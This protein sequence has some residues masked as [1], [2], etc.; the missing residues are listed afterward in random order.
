MPPFEELRP[1][2]A[3]NGE[4]PPDGTGWAYEVKWDGVRALTLI[5]DGRPQLRSRNGNDITGR[6]PELDGLTAMVP[7][8]RVILDG[9]VVAFDE[10]G[11]PSF[12]LLQ[13]R[14]HVTAARHA[15]DREAS[16]P[17]AYLIFDL[18]HLDGH[19][20]YALP[21]AERRRLLGDL[22]EP[23]PC[24]QIP[25]HRTAEGAALLTAVKAQGLEGVMAKRLDAPYEPGRR[26]SLWR[27][28]KVR[29]QQELVVGGWWPG[30][31]NRSDT[32]GS[33]LVGYYDRPG[34]ELRFAGKV[35]SGFTAAGL[36][37]ADTL[38][39]AL[40]TDRSPFAGPVPSLIAR[41]ARWVR[42]ERVAEVA[43]GEWTADGVLRHPSFLGWRDDKDPGEIV[44][45]PD[46]TGLG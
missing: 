40:A 4:L 6:Y 18:L 17:V 44:R 9:E 42:P 19:D 33:L 23:G 12:G 37:E 28:V 21:Y 2:T 5:A 36:A 1:M 13:T 43:F 20:L 39:R 15:R 26:S 31:G 35:G 29:R 34:G 3:V 14:M 10:Q 8:H 22:L 30:E 46:P 38:L 7:G 16:V 32:V 45:E 27:K 25:A 24:W 41:R 11:R